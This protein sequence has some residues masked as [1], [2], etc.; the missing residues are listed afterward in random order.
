MRIYDVGF[1]VIAQDA[2]KQARRPLSPDESPLSFL[3][4]TDP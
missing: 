4:R 2:K 3:K 1:R